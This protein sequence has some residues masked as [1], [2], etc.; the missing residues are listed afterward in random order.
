[1]ATIDLPLPEITVE[2]FPW[3]QTQFELVSGAKEWKDKKQASILP[4]LLRGKLVD[5][6]VEVD[7]TTKADL[8]LLKTAITK[9]TGLAQDPLTAGKL[10]I[11]HCRHSG[12]KTADFTD[13]LKKLF[14]QTYPDKDLTS[15][16]LLQCFLT[17][18][19][20]Q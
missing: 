6:Y 19:A 5:Y 1:M 16:I 8:K 11:S 12:E 10:F 14:K 9:K 2:E 3:A 20:P 13:H 4:M 17:G 18:L 7:A 15:G